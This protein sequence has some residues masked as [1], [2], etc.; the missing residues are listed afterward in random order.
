VIMTTLQ[1]TVRSVSDSPVIRYHINKQL[2]KLSRLHP[3]IT[4]CR[5][6]IDAEKKHYNRALIYTVTVD[7]SVPG[8][9]LVSKKYDQNLFVGIRNAF[10]ALEKSLHKYHD[11]KLVSFAR[12]GKRDR[13][14]SPSPDHPILPHAS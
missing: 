1:V 3:S 14:H 2:G 11:A 9:E 7:L 6:I 4:S 8:K 5:V 12:A 13:L 10:L